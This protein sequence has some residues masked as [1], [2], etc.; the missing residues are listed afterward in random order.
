MRTPAE[1]KGVAVPNYASPTEEKQAELLASLEIED[2]ERDI[3]DS[4]TRL[5]LQRIRFL[6]LE[7]SERLIGVFE[8]AKKIA[9]SKALS[10]GAS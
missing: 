2:L 7:E 3:P 9:V 4:N 5:T 6:D 8:R 1:N 10:G